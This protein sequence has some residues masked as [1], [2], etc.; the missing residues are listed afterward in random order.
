MNLLRE[1]LEFRNEWQDGLFLKVLQM[2][3]QFT[4]EL[5]VT[6]CQQTSFI[7][8]QDCSKLGAV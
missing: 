5:G 4:F 1:N 3:T 2:S 6:F 8:V 7:W